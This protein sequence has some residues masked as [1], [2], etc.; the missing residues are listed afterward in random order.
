MD[1][2]STRSFWAFLLTVLAALPACIQPRGPVGDADFAALGDDELE[3]ERIVEQVNAVESACEVTPQQL[4]AMVV[5]CDQGL[6]GDCIR[7]GVGYW[8]GCGAA[9]DQAH[10]EKFLERAC[11]LGSQTSCRLQAQVILES[12]T[13]R[14]AEAAAV[15]ERACRIGGK[16]ACGDLGVV[17][18]TRLTNPTATD[19]ERGI[20]VLLGAC[21][22]GYHV[23][24]T[25]LATIIERQKLSRH[26]EDARLVLK[27]AC[28]SNYL[29]AC[30]TLAITL[31]DGT[32]G[33]R[34]YDMGADLAARTCRRDHQPS[35]NALGHM[36]VLGHGVAK[37]PYRGAQLFYAA[38]RQ[39]Y[40]PACHS[41][42]E[43][44]EKGW[45]VG[46]DQGKAR[47][48]YQYACTIGSDYSCALLSV[49]PPA[50]NAPQQ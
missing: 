17:L 15:L 43:A 30:Y 1:G 39:R 44:V 36:F 38:C 23:F 14:P 24:C 32:L 18:T 31:E 12:K 21:R 11:S 10:A 41:M 26:F 34:D 9:P 7:A 2:F 8:R 20:T 48:F 6:R 50:P 35:C 19:R 13:P 16:R 25:R 40:A 37:D 33:L 22:A 3:V 49:P 27:Q 29:D 42:G 45:G 28:D 46:P 4:A 47:E 5:G